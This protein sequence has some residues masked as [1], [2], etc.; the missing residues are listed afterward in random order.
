VSTEYRRVTDR[1]TDRRTS[2]DGIVR[3]MH[4]RRAVKAIAIEVITIS[5]YCNTHIQNY[6]TYWWGRWKWRTWNYRTW[7]WRTELQGMKLQDMKMV[8]S[9]VFGLSDRTHCI[10]K[11]KCIGDDTK[12]AARQSLNCIKNKKIWRKTIFNMAD[13][14]LT[15]CNMARSWHWFR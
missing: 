12:P 2:C 15:P 7:N 8:W 9:Q 11:N 4:M 1:Q 6:Y 5:L 3:A 13:G 14:I 10:S